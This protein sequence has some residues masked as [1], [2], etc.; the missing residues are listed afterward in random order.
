[1]KKVRF[2]STLRLPDPDE[3]S[4]EIPLEDNEEKVQGVTSIV[5]PL[6]TLLEAAIPRSNLPDNT[7][8]FVSS[9][10]THPSTDQVAVKS[11]VEDSQADITWQ[12]NGS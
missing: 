3:D 9:L 8:S 2:D 1:M 4:D 10:S 6:P 11:L 5:V 7:L 12:D